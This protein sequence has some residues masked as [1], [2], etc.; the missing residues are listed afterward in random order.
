[1]GRGY[2]GVGVRA[3]AARGCRVEGCRGRRDGVDQ[4]LGVGKGAGEE[5][6]E[7]GGVARGDVGL[8][9]EGG[10]GFEGVVVGHCEAGRRR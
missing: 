8:P 7:G 1:M 2:G 6:G 9:G 3:W 10:E 5:V 4:E